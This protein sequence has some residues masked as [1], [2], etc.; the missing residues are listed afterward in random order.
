[1]FIQMTEWK[2]RCEFF[3][4][5]KTDPMKLFNYFLLKQGQPYLTMTDLD[6]PMMKKLFTGHAELLFQKKPT[7]EEMKAMSFEERQNASMQSRL[8]NF[9]GKK[10]REQVAKKEKEARAKLL[11]SQ[12]LDSFMRQ[13]TDKFGSIVRA[14]KKCLDTDGNGRLS[15]FEFV[16]A[17]RG[18]GYAGNIKLLWHVIIPGEESSKG[19]LAA[20]SEEAQFITLDMLDPLGAADIKTLREIIVK[21][22]GCVTNAWTQFLKMGANS[23]V[24]DE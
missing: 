17:C 6:P 1:M 13:L 3:G 23:G 14:W 7:H 24:V 15:Y 2:E 21:K 18:V 16:N 19:F 10:E 11:A 22:Y 8:G 4:W 9:I 20:D 5:T 12:C